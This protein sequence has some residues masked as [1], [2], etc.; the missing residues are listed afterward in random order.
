VTLK[1]HGGNIDQA[2]ARH[3]GASSDW[4]DLSTG[5][6]PCAYPIPDLPSQ[7][8]SDLPTISNKERLHKAAKSAWSCR[9]EVLAVSGA[10]AAIQMMPHFAPAAGLPGRHAK[11]LTPTYNEHANVLRLA[12]WNVEEVSQLEQLADCDLAIVVNPNNPNG[13]LY[14]PEQ[15]AALLP[16]VGRLVVDESFMDCETGYS[17]TTDTDKD[18]LIILRSFGKFYGLAGIRLGFVVA[19]PQ[20]IRVFNQLAGPWPVSGAA[21]EI[22]T[23]ALSDHK[24]QNETI[25]RLRKDAARLDILIQL[26]GATLVGGTPLF[27]LYDCP[28][29]AVFQDQLAAHHIWSRIFPYSQS[30]IR[31][32]LPGSQKD[33]EKLETAIKSIQKG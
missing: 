28:N 19:S 14:Q 26:S 31:L 23:T 5:I 1:D 13:R 17:L 6:N 18:G 21:I 29:A 20:D 7:A 16:H 30:F 2:M 24:W 15:L 12:G 25:L 32:G 10:Q 8:W 9:G 3:G 11:I 4:L 27:R 22:G 33:W